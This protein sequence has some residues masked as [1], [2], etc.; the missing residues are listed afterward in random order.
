MK[1]HLTRIALIVLALVGPLLA[2]PVA[3]RPKDPDSF[4][5]TPLRQGG[6]NVRA[7][8]GD[9]LPWLCLSG[10]PELATIQ[11]VSERP[12]EA[13]GLLRNASHAVTSAGSLQYALDMRMTTN[14][15]GGSE[16]AKSTL[17]GETT[18]RPTS[19]TAP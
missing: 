5:V 18:Q 17:V 1:A 4:Q 15:G 2:T 7:S 6:C 11:P 8:F 10:L 14:I 13:Q 19:C 9:P 3:A 12:A 16:T